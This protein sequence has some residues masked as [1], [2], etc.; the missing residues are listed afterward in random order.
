LPLQVGHWWDVLNC[1]SSS[2]GYPRGFRTA[3]RRPLAR[4]LSACCC[5]VLPRRLSLGFQRSPPS[6]SPL[7][8]HSCFHLRWV[9]PSRIS[10]SVHPCQWMDPVPPSWFLTTLTVFSGACLAGLLRPAADP[11]VHRVLVGRV[12]R[13]FPSGAMTFHP[14]CLTLR[15]L[16]SPAAVLLAW[17][18]SLLPL[19]IR[20]WFDSRAFLR[21]SSSSRTPMLPSAFA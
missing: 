8:V 3:G 9:E 11:G 10:A 2:G 12:P 7:A 19:A 6:N 1:S 4:K 21:R 5:L 16:S 18:P 15:S 14:R 13:G 17:T 20:R